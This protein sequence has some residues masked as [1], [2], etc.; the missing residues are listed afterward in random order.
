MIV[1][2]AS[3][4][5]ALLLSEPG[6][7]MVMEALPEAV[8]TET[9]LA[10]VYF[11]L[12]RRGVPETEITAAVGKTTIDL[13]PASD[14]RAAITCRL[15]DAALKNGLSNADRTCLAAGI[16]LDVPILTADKAWS[17]IGAINGLNVVQIR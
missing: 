7:E 3:A 2:D 5:L 16:V 10:E 12:S 15:T 1:L 4:L 14:E 13:L 9:N 6:E 8:M 17:K 11:A